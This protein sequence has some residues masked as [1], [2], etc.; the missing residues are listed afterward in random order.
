MGTASAEY[1]KRVFGVL[2]KNGFLLESDAKLPSVC[3]LITGEALHSSWWSHP[4]AQVIFQVNEQL[5]DHKDVL[6]TKLISGKVT[7]VHRRLWS[8][9]FAVASTR[10]PWQTK[11]LSGLARSLLHLIDEQGSLTT[12]RI[13]LPKSDKT[14]PGAVAR[15]LEKKLL[16]HGEQFHSASG[17]H[18]KLLETWE[19]W[20]KRKGFEASVI[21]AEQAKTTIEEGLR[22][23]NKQF[24][25]AATAPWQ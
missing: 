13:S 20:A 22:K 1:F 15:E 11:G 5:E 18:A 25:A 7:F 12:D 19:H 24:Q 6:I 2:K 14:K 21:T 10:E 23:L 8:E 16:I 3:T 9:L 4:L 17:A